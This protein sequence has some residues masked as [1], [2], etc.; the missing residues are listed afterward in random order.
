M[1]NKEKEDNKSK[2]S[3][4]VKCSAF[5]RK[6]GFME[7]GKV[8]KWPVPAYY[9]GVNEGHY[10]LTYECDGLIWAIPFS[11]SYNIKDIEGIQTIA[12][13]KSLPN[14]KKISENKCLLINTDIFCEGLYR[15]TLEGNQRSF[16]KKPGK[17][18][19]FDLNKVKKNVEKFLRIKKGKKVKDLD[20]ERVKQFGKVYEKKTE[21][22]GLV[23]VYII[24]VQSDEFNP[25]ACNSIL[26]SEIDS[27]LQL[28]NVRTYRKNFLKKYFQEVNW[29]IDKKQFIEILK[30]SAKFI[31][32]IIE[33]GIIE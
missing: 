25:I 2:K 10:F 8:K 7:K 21:M 20:K 30:K 23:K 29:Q 22:F 33:N 15:I 14:E 31:F 16:F 32:E 1:K 13:L 6:K 11:H 24:V 28:Q 9:G 4:I 19:V 12:K 26:C 5:T 17:I 18:A 27:N 3:K